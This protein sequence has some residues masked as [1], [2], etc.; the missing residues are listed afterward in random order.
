[1]IIQNC[2]LLLEI[3]T[4]IELMITDQK[5]QQPD[6]SDEEIINLIKNNLRDRNKL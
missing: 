1:M 5:T 6:L 2:N 3:I 4:K